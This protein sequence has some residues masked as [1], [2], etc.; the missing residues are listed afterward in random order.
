MTVGP[1]ATAGTEMVSPETSIGLADPAGATGEEVDDVGG[2]D[3]VV[4][5]LTVLAGGGVVDGIAGRS[6]DD[7]CVLAPVVAGAALLDPAELGGSVTAA[8]GVPAIVLLHAASAMLVVSSSAAATRRLNPPD[9]AG[10]PPVGS[11]T[12]DPASR[13]TIRWSGGRRIARHRPRSGDTP[14]TVVR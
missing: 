6:G 14:T 2:G 11:P 10:P 13:L 12:A 4:G 9:T 8:T 1:P 5:G 3:D 7:V